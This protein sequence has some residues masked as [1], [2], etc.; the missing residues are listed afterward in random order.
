MKLKEYATKIKN[1]LTGRNTKP[2]KEEKDDLSEQ[3]LERTQEMIK[4]DRQ[5]A[6]NQQQQ[7]QNERN[8][9]DQGEGT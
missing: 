7:A 4:E 1:R 2:Q 9:D 3:I 6:T 5:E 8:A